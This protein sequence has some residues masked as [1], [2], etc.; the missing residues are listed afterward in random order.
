LTLSTIWAIGI[1][2][3][4][5]EDYMVRDSVTSLSTLQVSR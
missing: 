3:I 5:R 1:D 2:S 4:S